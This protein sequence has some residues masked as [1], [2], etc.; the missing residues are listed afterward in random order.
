M[1]YQLH[2]VSRFPLVVLPSSRCVPGYAALWC[3]E[4]DSLIAA[5]DPFVIAFEPAAFEETPDDYRARAVWFKTHRSQLPGRCAG[6]VAVVPSQAERAALEP[7][8]A[9]RS[10]GFGVPYLAME[11][12]AAIEQETHRLVREALN[13]RSEE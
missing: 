13:F 8:L 7:D 2:D 12:F 11:S 6:M 4:M 5:A 3:A 10:K 9:K 1:P